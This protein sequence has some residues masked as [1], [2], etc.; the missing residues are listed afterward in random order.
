MFLSQSS[1]ILFFSSLGFSLVFAPLRL[2]LFFFVFML[3]SHNKR[4]VLCLNLCFVSLRV[5]RLGPDDMTRLRRVIHEEQNNSG[6]GTDIQH[7]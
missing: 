1:K 5:L 6:H 7:L 2:L 3:I 4:L